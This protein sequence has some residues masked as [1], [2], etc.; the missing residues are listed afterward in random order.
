MT[1]SQLVNK[2]NPLATTKSIKKTTIYLAEELLE[3]AKITQT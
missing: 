3:P 2:Y 1:V